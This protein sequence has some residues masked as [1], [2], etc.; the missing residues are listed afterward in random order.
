MAG[1]SRNEDASPS[2]DC[3]R[4]GSGTAGGGAPRLPQPPG[5]LSALSPGGDQQFQRCSSELSPHPR[6][7]VLRLQP[8]SKLAFRTWNFIS[9]IKC[10]NFLA[11]A[12]LLGWDP[13][14]W[15]GQG[16]RPPAGYVWAGSSM[17]CRLTPLMTLPGEVACPGWSGRHGQRMGAAF[18]PS[19]GRRSR[20]PSTHPGR[21]AQ[22]PEGPRHTAWLCSSPKHGPPLASARMGA[23]PN[24][25]LSPPGT[26]TLPG[27][28]W[29]RRGQPLPGSAHADVG[30]VILTPNRAT[31]DLS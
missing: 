20:P 27:R 11:M 29:V 22:A 17:G 8:C 16:A 6:N 10:F 7:S 25:R 31:H 13:R 4:C 23:G 2:E 1:G 15:G 12:C 24:T 28:G 30:S 3:S 14:P 18:A 19:P 21:P 9:Q 5:R 26:N